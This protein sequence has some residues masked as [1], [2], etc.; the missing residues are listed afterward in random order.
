M[1]WK[2]PPIICQWDI[3]G[4]CN[5][6]C[7]HCRAKGL[8]E[9]GKEL[10]FSKVIS[11][12]ENLFS[13]AP[14]VHLVFAGGEPLMRRDLR[15]I[16]F[17]TREQSDHNGGI[18]ILSNGTLIGRDNIEW[19]SET[20]DRFHISLEGAS[21]KAN[22]AI[23]GNGSFQKALDGI[24]LLL[25][26]D[27]A[28]AVRMTYLNQKEK[29]VESLVR[30]LPKIGVSVF[31]FRY[32]VP[33]GSAKGA[34]ISALQYE[35]LCRKIWTLGKELGVQTYYSDPFPAMLIDKESW[36][37]IERDRKLMSGGAV[38][39]C[40]I[41]FNALY[42]DPEG[43]VRACPY[44]PLKC[45]DANKKPL[46]KIWFQNKTLKSFRKIRGALEGKCG[47]CEYKFACGGCRAAALAEG[48]LLGGDPRCWK[49]NGLE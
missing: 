41:G 5:L 42:L 38:T 7:A 30:F 33:V 47:K 9:K 17:W 2:Y 6:R 43:I 21:P 18:D 25:D 27:V 16:L 45:D 36:E 46:E 24:S 3:T 15:E 44:L 35:R 32:V 22:D 10:G 34:F 31:N 1:T 28:V 29:E 39:G 23:R 26:Y 8:R 40:S 13:F 14:D 4:R 37:K 20:V 49:Y 19:L 12:L 48:N 11:I